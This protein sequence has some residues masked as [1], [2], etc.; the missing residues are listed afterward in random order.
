MSEQMDQF[1]QD[2]DFRYEYPKG[3]GGKSLNWKPGG[4]LHTKIV[5]AVG[6]RAK[7]CWS[8]GSKV[9]EECKKITHNM[10]AVVPAHTR[11][12]LIAKGRKASTPIDVMIPTCLASRDY[13]A[14]HAMTDFTSPLGNYPLQGRGPD[15]MFKAA[16]METVLNAQSEWFEHNQSFITFFRDCATFPAACMVPTWSKHI[17]SKSVS[18]EITETVREMIKGILPTAMQDDVLRMLEEQVLHEGNRLE[19]I[20]FNWLLL[21]PDSSTGDFE[22][23]QKAEFQ[24]YMGKGNGLD[25]LRREKDPEEQLMNCKYLNEWLERNSQNGRT[26]WWDGGFQ[27]ES[28]RN[29]KYDL[30]SS[31]PDANIKSHKFDYARGFWWLIPKQWDLGHSEE[32]ELWDFILAANQVLV[33]AKPVASWH[34]FREMLI[35][36]ITN[37]GYSTY[38]T[39]MLASVN[40]IQELLNWKVRSW[41]EWERKSL[42]GCTIMDETLLQSKEVLNRDDQSGILWTR[43]PLMGLGGLGNISNYIHQL[44]VPNPNENWPQALTVFMGLVNQ[45]MGTQPINMGGMPDRPTE[46]GVGLASNETSDRIGLYMLSLRAQVYTPMVLMM[47]MNTIQYLA[48]ERFYSIYGSRAEQALR[49]ELGLP[50]GVSSIPISA[51]DLSIDFQVVNSSH[52]RKA[53]ELQALQGMVDRFYSNPD[54]VMQTAQGIGVQNL[55]RYFASEMGFPNLYVF[56]Q[57]QGANINAQVVPDEQVMRGMDNGSLVPIGGAV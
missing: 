43:M 39:S 23:Q 36:S 48:E 46:L 2:K 13:F 50:P 9:R 32:P 53:T 54:V 15:G 52:R 45:I 29:D 1:W 28:G 25:F 51:A 16:I 5:N 38:P 55:F 47:A 21:D 57:E 42:N 7:Y 26:E 40:G 24:G 22:S 56:N 17:G 10:N 37:D 33:R 34:K 41:V 35:G 31:D 11:E 6:E 14:A 49:A 8:Y 27:D 4:K 30:G 12:T 3:S 19:N 18:M 44:S 20:D